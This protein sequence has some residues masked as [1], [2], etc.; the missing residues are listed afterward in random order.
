MVS[1]RR[2]NNVIRLNFLLA[3]GIVAHIDYISTDK[4]ASSEIAC[5]RDSMPYLFNDGNGKAFAVVVKRCY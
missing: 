4:F 1:I 2:V 3:Q 5:T